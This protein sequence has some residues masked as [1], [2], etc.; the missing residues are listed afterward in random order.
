[1]RLIGAFSDH[2]NVPEKR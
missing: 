1:M 2:A